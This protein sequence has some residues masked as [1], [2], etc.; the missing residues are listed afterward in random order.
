VGINPAGMGRGWGRLTSCG[1]G[2]GTRL[3]PMSLS[4]VQYIVC[5]LCTDS[6][7][8]MHRRSM[9]PVTCF[10]FKFLIYQ[11][12]RH[13]VKKIIVMLIQRNKI[14]KMVTKQLEDIYFYVHMF[15]A[16]LFTI[17]REFVTSDFTIRKY[18]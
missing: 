14:T 1:A 17:E 7:W 11:H 13:V 5:V 9:G 6:M 10:S 15:T 12:I 3:S 2:M 8:T 18:S 16:T 4:I